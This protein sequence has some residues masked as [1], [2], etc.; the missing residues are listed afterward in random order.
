MRQRKDLKRLSMQKLFTLEQDEKR[1]TLWWNPKRRTRCTSLREC[2]TTFWGCD[3]IRLSQDST[4]AGFKLLLIN[5]SK[6]P[7]I[8]HPYGRKWRGTK[9]PLDERERG[10]WK[11]WLKT[12]HSVN[13]DHGIWS[14]HFMTNRW[15]NSG[16][17]DRPSFLG[18]Q[19][20]C[21]W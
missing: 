20:Q 8:K 5:T 1:A 13:W 12:Q 18:L 2:D 21:R 16:N 15:R 19:N 7:L 17:S 11:I 14:H 9:E 3:S 10:E 6:A 4:S